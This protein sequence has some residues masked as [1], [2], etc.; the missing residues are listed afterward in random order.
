MPGLEGD[1]EANPAQLGFARGRELVE[2]NGFAHNLERSRPKS[3]RSITVIRASPSSVD[4]G[5][6]LPGRFGTAC[7]DGL[8]SLAWL[9]FWLSLERSGRE[10]SVLERLLEPDRRMGSNPSE[11]PS[12]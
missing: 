4:M 10:F 1:S 3:A 5:V 11:S 12:V 6:A 9:L 7:T 2:G 8:V